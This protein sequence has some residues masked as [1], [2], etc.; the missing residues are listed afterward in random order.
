MN[1]YF[2]RCGLSFLLTVCVSIVV[3]LSVSDQE[4]IRGEDLPV[5]PPTATP[6]PKGD[7]DKSDGA[8]IML[9]AQGRD[10]SEI[11]DWWAVVQWQDAAGVWHD[12]EGWQGNFNAQHQVSWRIAPKDFGTGP[13][14]WT[15]FESHGRINVVTV[16]E[17]FWLPVA[18]G[19]TMEIVISAPSK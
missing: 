9:L 18:S 17:E 8:R 13:F 10:Y 7:N 3:L 15:V 16:S 6:E 19:R 2:V 11:D 4:V 14:R 1:K 5:R 12:V